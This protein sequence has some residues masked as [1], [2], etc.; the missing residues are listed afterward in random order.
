MARR[1]AGGD[2][3]Q[4]ATPPTL[5]RLVASRLESPFLAVLKPMYRVGAPGAQ[6]AVST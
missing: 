2:G 3:A 1:R 6:L 5:L 4:G